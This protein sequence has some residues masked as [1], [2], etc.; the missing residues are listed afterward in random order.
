MARSLVGGRYRLDERLGAGGMS[1][2]WAAE[3]VELG[4]RVAIKLLGRDADAA[5]FERE[6]HA[7]AQLTHP[8]ICQLY[9]YGEARGRP[10][11]V[12][13]YLGGGTL[14]D[15]LRPDEPYPDD[16]TRRVARELA[17]AL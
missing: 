13:E 7:V 15:R 4:R 1:E 17:S 16:E 11:M 8:N 14:E 9:D 3:D 10:F 12:L 6:A 5:R 2:V